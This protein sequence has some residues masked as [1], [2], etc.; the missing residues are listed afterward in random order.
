MQSNKQKL[1]KRSIALSPLEKQ[2][3]GF[4][5]DNVPVR[6]HRMCINLTT[7]SIDP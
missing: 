1:D 6:I 5:V 7:E 2:S 4:R 3:G